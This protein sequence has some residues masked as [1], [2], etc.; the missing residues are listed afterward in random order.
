M[1]GQGLSKRGLVFQDE[2]VYECSAVS[3]IDASDIKDDD[4]IEEA[5]KDHHVKDI[6]LKD[7][8]N[9][10]EDGGQAKLMS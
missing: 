1:K 2:Q 7:A 10:L 6:K 8:T 4:T 5:S 9:E 3:S